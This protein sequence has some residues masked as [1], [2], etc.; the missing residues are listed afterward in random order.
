MSH[1]LCAETEAVSCHLRPSGLPVG[2][3]DCGVGHVLRLVPGHSER[4]GLVGL[5]YAAPLSLPGSDEPDH[6]L[7][8][9][10]E[11]D[12]QLEE[13]HHIQAHFL[14]SLNGQSI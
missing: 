6:E 13:Q 4:F 3:V 9:T 11:E 8:L 5:P 14:H 7:I 1:L 2:Y 12:H 10:P